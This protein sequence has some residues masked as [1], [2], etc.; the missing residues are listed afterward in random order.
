[1]HDI[2]SGKAVTGVIHFYNKTIWFADP[3]ENVKVYF[4]C[5]HTRVSYVAVAHDALALKYSRFLFLLLYIAQRIV[6]T[7]TIVE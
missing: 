2:L 3:I 7:L 1:M 5:I 4:I 6:Q